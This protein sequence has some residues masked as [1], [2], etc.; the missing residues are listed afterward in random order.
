MADKKVS[1]RLAAVAGSAMLAAAAVTVAGPVAFVAFVS[2]PLAR[3][4][5]G[6]GPA[7]ATAAMIGAA[8]VVGADLG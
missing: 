7:L 1:V 2:G 4:L 8:M 6:H 5:R 3:R